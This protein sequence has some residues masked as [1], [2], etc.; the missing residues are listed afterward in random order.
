M[1]G[2]EIGGL[3]TQ[4]VGSTLKNSRC[5]W[6]ARKNNGGNASLWGRILRRGKLDMGWGRWGI[7]KYRERLKR[8]ER[9]DDE[10]SDQQGRKGWNPN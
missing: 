10:T 1:A 8:Q 4:S 6:R 5:N 7:S 9:K 2:N 3:D